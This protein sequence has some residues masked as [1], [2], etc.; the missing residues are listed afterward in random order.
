MIYVDP[1]NNWGWVLNGKVTTSCHMFTD[2]V[3]LDEL[4]AM[5]VKIGMRLDWFQD[6]EGFPHYDL[7]AS[8]RALAVERGAIEVTFRQMRH[9]A[10]VRDRV[11]KDGVEQ[12]A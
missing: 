10:H 3:D 6:R 1:L 4:H 2:T 12:N 5:A 7:T 9:I 11:F 8:R